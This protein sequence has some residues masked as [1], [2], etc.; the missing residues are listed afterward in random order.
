MKSIKKVLLLAGFIPLLMLQPIEAKAGG[1]EDPPHGHGRPE[2]GDE[3]IQE[4]GW[5]LW[6][7]EKVEVGSTMERMSSQIGPNALEDLW[8]CIDRML[9]TIR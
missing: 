5:V 1:D 4:R 3:V 2:M 6:P 8:L 9:A 7:A